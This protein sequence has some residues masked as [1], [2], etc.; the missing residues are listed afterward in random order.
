MMIKLAVGLMLI[1]IAG[2]L[3]RRNM[4]IIALCML[5]V[6]SGIVLLFPALLVGEV[7]LSVI[8]ILALCFSLILIAMVSVCV[9]IYRHRGTL[10]LDELRVLRD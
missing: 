3:L 4:L 5:V 6:F 7:Y 8:L 1:G 2:A 9:L 10:H